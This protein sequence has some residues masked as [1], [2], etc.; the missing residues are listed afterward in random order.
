[1]LERVGCCADVSILPGG[2]SCGD[3]ADG[4]YYPELTEEVCEYNNYYPEV[5]EEVCEYNN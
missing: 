5:T 3:K 4:E 2:I 1:M